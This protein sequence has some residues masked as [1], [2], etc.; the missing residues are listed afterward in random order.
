M[1][2]IVLCSDGVWDNWRYCDVSKFVMDVSCVNAVLQSG[3]GA[4]RVA[5]SFMKRNTLYSERNFGSQADN[6]TGIVLYL[7]TD[8]NFPEQI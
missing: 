4:V 7:S 6:A 5:K 1:L 8:A 2:C 3:D